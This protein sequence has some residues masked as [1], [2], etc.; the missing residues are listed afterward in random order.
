MICGKKN[1]FSKNMQKSI[2]IFRKKKK[3]KFKKYAKS[4]Y[5]EKIKKYFFC[6]KYAKSIISEK[7]H[8]LHILCK[9]YIFYIKVTFGIEFT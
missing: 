4:E 3:K 7:K 1:F 8:F 9:K 6:I 5:S 2:Y